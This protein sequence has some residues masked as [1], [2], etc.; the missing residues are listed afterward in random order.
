MNWKLGLFLYEEMDYPAAEAWLDH[1]AARGWE[2]DRLWGRLARFR[3]SGREDLHYYVDLHQSPEADGNDPDG[4]Y[5]HCAEAGWEYVTHC[6][7]MAVFAS[8]PVARPEPV[9]TGGP[10]E[11]RTY[12]RRAIRP[13]VLGNLTALLLLIA[14]IWVLGWMERSGVGHPKAL[15]ELLCSTAYLF[16]G[17]GIL[18]TLVGLVWSILSGLCHW[19]RWKRA[20]ERGERPRLSQTW[21]RVRGGVDEL[22]RLLMGLYFLCAL[23]ELA[24]PLLG[25]SGYD[26]AARRPELREDPLVMAEEVGVDPAEVVYLAEEP[27]FSL[28][29]RGQ[30]YWENARAE[31]GYQS[32][33]CE[34]YTCMSEGY[35]SLLARAI[36]WENSRD[37]YTGYGLL[38]FVPA[39]LGTDEAWSAR[40]GAFL[41]LRE[42]RTVALVGSHVMD[43]S[44]RD[45]TAPEHLVDILDRLEMR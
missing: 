15:S 20:A 29:V 12:W 33:C 21:A 25:Y 11:R 45:L 44:E 36:C 19:Q 41:L 16:A 4:Y 26:V 43:G 32:V 2:L 23:L 1:Q 40:D 6:G 28:L 24:L 8:S 13:A 34:R 14:L 35:A 30:L 3:R 17:M 9:H 39:E 10:M 22:G 38:E 7:G 37:N 18:C 31:G 27:V 5:Q 42:G